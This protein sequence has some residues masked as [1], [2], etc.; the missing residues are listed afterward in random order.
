MRA[1][2]IQNSFNT[3]EISPYTLARTD[4]AKYKNACERLENW[5]PLITGGITRRPGTRFLVPALGPSRLIPFEFSTTQTFVLELG[6]QVMRF[7]TRAADGT[8]GIILNGMAPYSIATPWNTATDDLW[9]IKFAQQGDV[10][11]LTHPNRPPQKLSRVSDTNWILQAPGFHS[12]PTHA[13][14]QDVSGGAITLTPAATTGRNINF[15]ASAPVFIAGDVGKFIVVGAGLAIINS[16]N[17]ATAVDPVTKADLSTTAVCDIVDALQAGGVIAAGDWLLRGPPSGYLEY[18][19]KNGQDGNSVHLERN[20]GAFGP[21][22]DVYTF[23]KYEADGQPWPGDNDQHC[24]REIDVGRYLIAG[25][26]VGIIT[27]L[28]SASHVLV[29]RY[30]PIEDTTVAA[31]NGDVVAAPSSGG[32]WFVEDEAFSAENGYPN[33]VTFDQDR[34]IYAGTAALPLQIWG[35]RTGDY[36]NFAKGPGDADGLDFGIDAAIQSQIRGLCEFRGNLGVFT[37]RE[38]YMVGGGIITLSSASPQA[39]TPGNATAVRQSKNG[40]SRVQPQVIQNMLL[41]LWRSARNAS[42]MQ[43]NIYQANFGSRN[44]NILHELIATTPIKEMAWQEFP[45]FVDWF[46]TEGGGT[47]PA[48]SAPKYVCD[49]PNTAP[50]VAPI[51]FTDDL[52]TYTPQ[53]ALGA[54]AQ[55]AGVTVNGGDLYYDGETV[56]ATQFVSPACIMVWTAATGWTIPLVVNDDN[57]FLG[58]N[59]TGNQPERGSSA[60]DFDGSVYAVGGQDVNG[61]TIAYVAS[62]PSAGPWTL[63]ALDA[64]QGFDGVQ[65]M[66]WIPRLNKWII[67]GEQIWTADKGFTNVRAIYGAFNDPTGNL[68]GEV[69]FFAALYDDGATVWILGEGSISSGQAQKLYSTVDGVTVTVHNYPSPFPWLGGA[70]GGPLFYIASLGLWVGSNLDSANSGHNLGLLW[71][72]T[73]LGPWTYGYTSPNNPPG[74]P[75]DQFLEFE[76]VGDTVYVTGFRETLG[77]LTETAQ[78]AKTTDGK[79][80]TRIEPTLPEGPSPSSV[81]FLG[82][83]I[84]SADSS[85]IAVGLFSE[86]AASLQSNVLSDDGGATLTTKFDAGRFEKIIPAVAAVPRAGDLIGLTYE[87]EQQVW[88]WHRHFTGQD[89]PDGATDNFVSVATAQNP[90]NEALDDLWAVTQRTVNGET[91]YFV[92]IFDPTLNTDAALENVFGGKVTQVS[93]LAYLAGRTVQLKVDGMYLGKFLVPSSGVIDFSKVLPEGG[94][95]V[96]VGL[97]YTSIALTVRPE[98][99]GGGQ[100]IQGLKKTWQRVFARVYNAINLVLGAGPASNTPQNVDSGTGS[101]PWRLLGRRASDPIG[102]GVAPFTGDVELPGN[103]GSDFDGRVLVEQDQPFACTVL[104]PFGILTIGDQ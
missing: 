26:A 96:E 51:L 59:G 91:V 74:S 19:I 58:F 83:M 1:V 7:F 93:G 29:R 97:P 46:T 76:Q 37:P 103:L 42:E 54:L 14:D 15:V 41:Y 25:G 68:T 80:W 23:A 28:V 63:V 94:F 98:V 77:P 13:F 89:L 75:S 67:V 72:T 56:I 64:N 17:K 3:G 60:I 100:T 104:A 31:V 36:E 87:V 12:P 82:A 71:A 45:N 43:Y 84:G 24:F 48:A 20:I 69:D 40:S 57:T 5:I 35:S 38:E 85:E 49:N 55:A 33:A 18:A 88:G 86:G 53:T 30:S 81:S 2:V 92:E 10:M 34:L 27:S 8:P 39:L 102:G 47:A 44:L 11:Y 79:T 6:N 52:K 61:N 99:G 21:P 73:P 95:D 65:F 22:R 101:G 62:N 4:L 78:L 50:P 66:K 9:D 70:P 16:L 90:V 32:T